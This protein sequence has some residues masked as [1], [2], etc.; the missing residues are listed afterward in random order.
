MAHSDDVTNLV[1][2]IKD[3]PLDGFIEWE[4]ESYVRAKYMMQKVPVAPD[5]YGSGR[6]CLLAGDIVT[7][8][9]IRTNTLDARNICI[10]AWR[11]DEDKNA[12]EKMGSKANQKHSEFQY[13]YALL[14]QDAGSDTA[15]FVHYNLQKHGSTLHSFSDIQKNRDK[16]REGKPGYVNIPT[17]KLQ[18]TLHRNNAET[19]ISCP[20]PLVGPRYWKFLQESNP[21]SSKKAVSKAGAAAEKKEKTKKKVPV[22]NKSKATDSSSKQK[23]LDGSLCEMTPEEAKKEEQRRKRRERDQRKREQKRLEALKAAENTTE[24]PAVDPP[25]A[26]EATPSQPET[27]PAEEM[28]AEE[29]RKALRREKD[30]ERRRRQKEEKERLASQQAKEAMDVTDQEVQ[31]E[32]PSKTVKAAAGTSEKAP[33]KKRT[34]TK[35]PTKPVVPLAQDPDPVVEAPPKDTKKKEKPMKHSKRVVDEEEDEEESDRD[36]KAEKKKR[37]RNKKKDKKKKKSKRVYD[38]DDSSDEDSESESSDESEYS[39]KRKRKR[40]KKKSKKSKK[41]RRRLAD[42]LRDDI[43]E[44]ESDSDS[45]D[46]YES[47]YS[48]EDESEEE[49]PYDDDGDYGEGMDEAEVVEIEDTLEGGVKFA[50]VPKEFISPMFSGLKPGR[51]MSTVQKMFDLNLDTIKYGCDESEFDHDEKT[52]ARKTTKASDGKF[53]SVFDCRAT[54]IHHF[55]KQISDAVKRIVG[56]TRKEPIKIRIGSRY[57]TPMPESYFNFKPSPN[58]PPQGSSGSSAPL[59]RTSFRPPELNLTGPD[60]SKF[61][62][63]FD[64][65][66]GL[67]VVFRASACQLLVMLLGQ[68][69]KMDTKS[70]Q[71]FVAP[72]GI[73]KIFEE[74]RAIMKDPVEGAMESNTEFSKFILKNPDVKKPAAFMYKMFVYH[75]WPGILKLKETV[76][77][78]VADS[79]KDTALRMKELCAQY[80]TK[81]SELSTQAETAQN[82]VTSLTLALANAESE[83]AALKE[84]LR[85][86]RKTNRPLSLSGDSEISIEDA[87]DAKRCRTGDDEDSPFSASTDQ[88]VTEKEE[89]VDIVNIFD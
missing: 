86:D 46:S 71:A 44:S 23:T 10:L 35:I 27:Q 83:L 2:S 78:E 13:I 24:P 16:I 75:M 41:P 7:D 87:P 15:R 1:F 65:F 17:G 61:F 66:P 29:K 36:L 77:K 62:S 85:K 5:S 6:I 56:T 67:N 79:S 70:A 43:D 88:G 25:Q 73:E 58:V 64:I 53:M 4:S 48:D 18:Y 45:D 38:S 54:H 60:T 21:S 28:D 50:E 37:K 55:C 52:G 72:L 82:K 42:E 9:D 63:F 32:K 26:E 49:V 3:R 74:T 69:K 57:Q 31:K 51:F 14:R 20:I 34:P 19:P 81:I 30:R 89:A 59:A 33:K 84:Q 76:Q 8:E 39:R 80:E 40:S 68:E 47:S 11:N 12:I 22:A